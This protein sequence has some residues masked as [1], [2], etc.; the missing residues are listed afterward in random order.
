MNKE[1]QAL[2]EEIIEEDIEKKRKEKEAKKI[3]FKASYEE[4]GEELYIHIFDQVN[5]QYYVFFTDIDMKPMI[6]WLK[7]QGYFETVNGKYMQFECPIELYK[8]SYKLKYIQLHHLVINTKL[9][10]AKLTLPDLERANQERQYIYKTYNFHIDHI[11]ERK[12]ASRI[13]E[14]YENEMKPQSN[15]R[16]DNLIFIP[17]SINTN[18][19]TKII[20]MVL[21]NYA[22]ID[23][24]NN[25]F[26]ITY[27]ST[28]PIEFEPEEVTHIVMVEYDLPVAEEL[29]QQIL[30]QSKVIENIYKEHNKANNRVKQCYSIYL[31]SQQKPNVE[32]K[33]C[34]YISNIYYDL[35][36]NCHLFYVPI[37]TE[38]KDFCLYLDKKPYIDINIPGIKEIQDWKNWHR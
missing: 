23:H 4:I 12:L 25:K 6:D 14:F 9:F 30:E 19:K 8:P 36:N 1:M 17:R 26:Y 37:E 20:D 7:G 32:A 13:Y 35:F 22:R 31:Q 10:N 33:Y 16:Y 28:I 18:L 15:N 2:A 27:Y 29:E 24:Y 5:N 38:K 34:Y 11:T 21:G 3:Q